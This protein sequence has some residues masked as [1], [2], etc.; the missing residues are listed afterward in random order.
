MAA[1]ESWCSAEMEMG[2]RTGAPKGKGG[3]P[4]GQGRYTCLVDASFRMELVQLNVAVV[5]S[6]VAD[7]PPLRHNTVR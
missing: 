2:V 5:A 1:G 7:E 3:T 4:E 6:F